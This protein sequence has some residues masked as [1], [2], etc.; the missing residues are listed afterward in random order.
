MSLISNVLQIFRKPTQDTYNPQNQLFRNNDRINFIINQENVWILWKKSYIKINCTLEW[1]PL[2]A[3]TTEEAFGQVTL[4]NNI[5]PFLFDSISYYLN[6]TEI[7]SVDQVGLVSTVK[8]YLCFMKNEFEEYQSLGWTK[9]LNDQLYTFNPR[10]K[11]FSLKLKLS[12]MLNLPF[13][14]ERIMCGTHKMS[15][16]RSRTD[17]NCYVST[18]VRKARITITDMN[19]V[20]LH[21]YPAVKIQLQLLDSIKK[22]RAIPL[23]FQKWEIQSKDLPDAKT[24]SWK[25]QTIQRVERPNWIIV[26][27]QT[28]RDFNS[29]NILNDKF[30]N[31]INNIIP[32]EIDDK[33]NKSINKIEK[34]I[35]DLT[36][37]INKINNL[38]EKEKTNLTI[39]KEIIENHFNKMEQYTRKILNDKFE[40]IINNII[41][42][43]IDDKLNKS[44]NKIEKHIFD[45]TK[46][47]NIIDNLFEK[48]KTNLTIN[49]EIIG[50]H[51]N[52]MEQI[53]FDLHKVFEKFKQYDKEMN[54][55][56][57]IL[58]SKLKN[59]NNIINSI[60]NVLDKRMN[61]KITTILDTHM[62]NKI[63]IKW[64][65][66][67]NNTN[68]LT[69]RIKKLE[70]EYNTLDKKR[71]TIPKTITNSKKMKNTN[72]KQS[73]EKIDSYE[74]TEIDD[75]KIEPLPH[76]KNKC[77]PGYQA[78]K[79][80]KHVCKYYEK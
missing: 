61:N 77:L 55:K 68:E 79:Y 14:Y 21:V 60:T 17:D 69:N 65:M 58:D 7:D 16:V 67:M 50:N 72:K 44:I 29:R 20:A 26:F 42:T 33:L 8:T 39:N 11:K 78:D 40:N 19:L 24:T 80:I 57:G 15:L 18:G 32:T 48:E 10:T 56:I 63:D 5:G 35:F 54:S 52:K 41:P 34:H 59:I 71:T 46:K 75:V 73:N 13:T 64:K 2:P 62:N 23:A 74:N 49:K 27:F 37:K 66:L 9:N 70:K 43:E 76:N 30:E 28:E 12:Q 45:I 47:I 36:K 6:N 38:F 51:F 25:I 53:L 22:N 31:I 3:N 4:I 1:D